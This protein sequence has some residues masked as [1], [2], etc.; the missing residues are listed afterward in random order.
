MARSGR[1]LTLTRLDRGRTRLQA[2]T[3]RDHALSIRAPWEEELET[4]PVMSSLWPA[5]CRVSAQP[6]ISSELPKC[7]GLLCV[8]LSTETRTQ[9][10]TL[11]TRHT[12]TE[13]RPPLL[14]GDS[15]QAF[16]CCAMPAGIFYCILGKYSTTDLHPQPTFYLFFF[17]WT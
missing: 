7:Y 17:F 6:N 4:S 1:H 15:K 14:A 16:P 10:L 3:G 13:P 5:S 8:C 12:I 9:G 2:R 11:A